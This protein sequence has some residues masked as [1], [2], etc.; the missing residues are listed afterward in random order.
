MDSTL[1][2]YVCLQHFSLHMAINP[3]CKSVRHEV[4]IHGDKLICLLACFGM[5]HYQGRHVCT[6]S[7]RLEQI[8]YLHEQETMVLIKSNEKNHGPISHV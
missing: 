8:F 2:E 6:P 3:K 5:S 7:P 1:K 4:I